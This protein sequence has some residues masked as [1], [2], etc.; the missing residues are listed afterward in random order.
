MIRITTT[1]DVHVMVPVRH[2]CPLQAMLQLI[3]VVACVP[4]HTHPPWSI[5]TRYLRAST[6]PRQGLMVT[7]RTT[8][9]ILL[10]FRL[11]NAMSNTSWK[12]LPQLDMIPLY[13]QHTTY[14]SKWSCVTDM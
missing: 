13:K 12:V 7:T 5:E 3:E 1:T 6:V 11:D 14:V 4:R 2:V 10:S 8:Y 9:C